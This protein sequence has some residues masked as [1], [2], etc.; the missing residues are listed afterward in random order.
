MN[1]RADLPKIASSKRSQTTAEENKAIVAGSLAYYGTYSV[2]EAEK[3]ITVRIEGSTFA[4]QVG[5]VQKRLITLI[6]AEEMRFTNPAAT[7]GG[8][9]E[10]VWR[11]VAGQGAQ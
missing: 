9:L 3:M 5:T 1:V 10:L 2:G 11:R 6:T 8:S 4:N 7:S